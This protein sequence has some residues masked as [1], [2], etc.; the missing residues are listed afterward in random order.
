MDENNSIKQFDINA[1]KPLLVEQFEEFQ[2]K[3]LGVQR[4]QLSEILNLK[5][6]PF[7]VIVSGLRRA[8]KSTLL[9]QAIKHMY[10]SSEYY[11]VNFDDTRFLNFSAEDF[12]Q[13]QQ[14]LIEIFGERKVFVFDEIQNIKGWEVFIRRLLNGS[15]KIYITGSNANL[16][17]KE[18]GTHLT[19]RYIPISLYPFSFREFLSFKNENLTDKTL[20]IKRQAKL[21]TLL[22]EYIIKG[23]I[24]D[25]LKY[26]NITW[27]ET[28]Y[29][30]IIY[31]DIIARQKIEEEKSLKELSLYLMSN[32][33]SLISFNKLKDSLKLGSVNTVKSFI[34]YLENSWLT[35]TI[36]RFAYSV[37]TQQI[38]AKKSYVIDTGLAHTIGF[39]FSPNNGKFLENLVFLDLKRM[40]KEI[41]YY[42]T[43]ANHEIDFYIRKE[44]MLIQVC[45][46]LHNEVTRKREFDGLFEAMNEVLS[47]QSIIVTFEHEEQILNGKKR[48]NCIP[49]SKFAN[50]ILL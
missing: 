26:T 50:N 38:A 35:F 40:K 17:S 31:R 36:N 16:L 48:I 34:E 33:A 43:K 20:I 1:L 15:Y 22:S 5:D 27:H 11:Y 41:F 21:N 3:D 46:D 25:A 32:P 6:N 45:Y 39:S 8:G 13:L 23:G 44:N 12:P 42:K 19:G 10:N 18:L 47:E 29:N 24:P 37:K 14:I 9:V 28:L 49:Y 2:T 4:E 7:A 30:D